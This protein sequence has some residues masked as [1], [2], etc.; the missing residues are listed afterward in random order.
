[1]HEQLERLFSFLVVAF[2]FFCCWGEREAVL[3]EDTGPHDTCM[4]R[5][6]KGSTGAEGIQGVLT[7]RRKSKGM[8]RVTHAA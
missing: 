5:S 6:T 3:V 2:L 1:M 8:A 4:Q 7:T